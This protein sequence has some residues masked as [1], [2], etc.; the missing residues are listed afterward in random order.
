MII[1]K[2]VEELV[3]MQQSGRIVAKVLHELRNQAKAGRTTRQIDK[4]GFDVIKKEGAEPA[5]LGYRGFP[6][7]VCTSVNEQVVHGIPG[8][9][10]L[11]DGDLLSLDIGVKYQGYYADAAITVGVG[12]ID[13]DAENLLKVARQALHDGIEQAVVGNHLYDISAA[14]QRRAESHGYSVVRD[15]VG[16]GIGQKMHEDPQV[17]NF[18]QAGTGPV[19]KEGMVLA[20]EPMVN[21]G[22]S[23]VKILS[24][25]W[26][27]VTADSK[28]SA[29][30]EHTVAVTGEGPRI[31]TLL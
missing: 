24:D 29:H 4:I 25:Q 22:K 6:A 1:N 14:I 19:L 8:E 17:P 12:E 23:D 28:R 13:R 7:S 11:K 26:T 9:R 30:F 3:V 20:L 10:M 21:E 31:L 5:F 16:H 15:F 18:G 27:V 2:S